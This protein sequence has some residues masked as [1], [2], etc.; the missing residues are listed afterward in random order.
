MGSVLHTLN[1]RLPAAHSKRS[2]ISSRSSMAYRAGVKKAPR[3][4]SRKPI[5]HMWLAIRVS[6]AMMTRMYSA[7]SG[8]FASS[9]IS[10]STARA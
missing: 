9:P 8:G 10:C 6:S 7:R 3:S 5:D 2:R 1:I 4:L